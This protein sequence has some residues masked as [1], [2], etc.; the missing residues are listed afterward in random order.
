MTTYGNTSRVSVDVVGGGIAGISGPGE[1][2][3]VL[4]AEGDPGSGSASANSPTQVSGPGELAGHFGSG[5]PIVSYF[6]QIAENGVE[7]AN[8]WGVMPEVMNAASEDITGGGDA[9]DHTGGSRLSNNPIVEDTSTI[10]FEDDNNNALTVE[11]RYE[12]NTDNTTSDFTNLTPPSETVYINPN[13]GEWVADT[14]DNYDVT[15]DW[16]DWSSAFD[17]ATDVIQEQEVGVWGVGSESRD[18][19]DD[20]ESTMGPLRT[21]E[22]KMISLLGLTEPNQSSSDNDGT[23]DVSNYT[24]NID[25]DATFLTGPARLLDDT[26]TALG[27]VAGTMAG[28]AISDPITTDR[29][30]GIEDLEQTLTVP[31]QELF[32]GEGII[33]LSN[34]N[35]PPTIES[36]VGT[37]SAT[38]WTRTFFSRRL[39][40]RF[41]LAARSA[42]RT[43]RGELN[44]VN[45]QL[46]VEQLLADEMRELVQ[47]GVLEPN[48]DDDQ[49][50]FVEATEDPDN[51]RELDLS[52]GF[53]PTG[54]VDIVDVSET[55]NY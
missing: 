47:E 34:A 8:I 14:A 4:F 51:P 49:K 38:D 46:I 3:V 19:I 11:F 39:A 26:L 54:V 55:I 16:L 13:T 42:A 2:K 35:T 5:E 52:F 53:T 15:Y 45:T 40:D 21:Q 17:S 10:T 27:A 41:I 1:R 9:A 23:Q 12:T 36:N 50:W 33:V 25:A 22:W 30:E 43:A 32:E 24:D 18:V 31:D 29:L 20:A 44:N 7:Y 28:N 48:T 37:S 6:Q